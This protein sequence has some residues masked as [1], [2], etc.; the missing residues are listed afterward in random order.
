[1]SKTNM[2]T[3]IDLFFAV[4]KLLN[5]EE[6]PFPEREILIKEIL[7]LSIPITND[8]DSFVIIR[9]PLPVIL[10]QNELLG[11]IFIHAK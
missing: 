6:D 2:F 9:V 1:M 8:K 11:T 10:N 7:L 5:P 4:A 3:F